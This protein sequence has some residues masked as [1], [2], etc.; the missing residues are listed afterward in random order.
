MLYSKGEK[1][2]CKGTGVCEIIDI[3]KE[4]FLDTA[5]K[6]YV[7][8][9]VN[10]VCP[11]KIFVPV[12]NEAVRL[13]PLITK[14]EIYSF[15]KA[16]RQEDSLWTE[17]E[18]QREREF[19]EI[20]KSEDFSKIIKLISEIYSYEKERKK[21]GGKIRLS[22]EK[23]LKEAEKMISTEFAFVLDI[24]PKEVKSFILKELS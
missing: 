8:M 12:A 17:D 6:Y 10:E 21:N 9:S 23:I 19:S 20:L 11:T 16:V 7:L 13:R 22:D 5:E 1:V 4:K 15:V 3:R 2:V 14:E 18:K 24:S